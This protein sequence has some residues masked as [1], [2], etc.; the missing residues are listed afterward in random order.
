MLKM[1]SKFA[2][3]GLS[4]VGVNMAIY[5][6]VI[7]VQANYMVAAACSFGVAVTN[8]FIWNVLWTFKGRAVDRS[9]AI[10]Y[11]SFFVISTINLGVNLLILQFLVE[12]LHVNQIMAQLGAITMASGLNF[13]LNYWITFGER[14]RNQVKEDTGV[15]ETNRYTYL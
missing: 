1:L 12:S 13:L 6:F 14:Q 5:L 2:L 15:Y 7:T 10:K 8:N 3:V 11:I 9:V 4:G